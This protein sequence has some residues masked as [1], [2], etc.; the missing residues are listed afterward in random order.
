MS[1]KAPGTSIPKWGGAEM[2]LDLGR[3]IQH[4]VQS[5]QFL[6][7]GR[8]HTSSLRGKSHTALE[9]R[10]IGGATFQPLYLGDR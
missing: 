3:R 10:G 8:S 6:R 2:S 5:T 4:Q 1:S 9:G 7:V